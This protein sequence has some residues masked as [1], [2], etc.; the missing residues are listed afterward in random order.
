MIRRLA[1][2]LSGVS[3]AY[4]LSGLALLWWALWLATGSQEGSGDPASSFPWAAA[5]FAI[6]L[7]QVIGLKSARRVAMAAVG[8]AAMLC[9]SGIAS[10]AWLAQAPAA[11]GGIYALFAGLDAWASIVL[12]KAR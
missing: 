1:Y 5:C 12:W 6:G 9:W 10:V 3:V 4:L 7:M 2:S 8:W 11:A